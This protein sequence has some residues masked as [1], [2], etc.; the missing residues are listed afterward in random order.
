M[1]FL[2]GSTEMPEIKMPEAP[3]VP[4]ALPKEEDVKE[5]EKKKL[6]KGREKRSTILTSERG[7]TGYQPV[8][9]KTLLG[10]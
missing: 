5:E 10:E 7:V 2:F 4:S 8:Q 9:R 1:S 3:K 6:R